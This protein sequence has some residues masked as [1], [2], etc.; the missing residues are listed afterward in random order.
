MLFALERKQR[1]IGIINDMLIKYVFTRG[2]YSHVFS[3][4]NIAIIALSSVTAIN[5]MHLKIEDN[6]Y[7]RLI[8]VI[9]TTHNND[10]NMF[11]INIKNIILIILKLYMVL[12]MYNSALD[13]YMFLLNLFY[14][15][16]QLALL[17]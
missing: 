9:N 12:L 17:S 7:C 2:L 13:I 14:L 6:L 15:F 8:Y 11:A 1:N 10:I 5:I 4:N 16:L 3:V